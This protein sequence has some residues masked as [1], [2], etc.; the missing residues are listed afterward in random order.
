MMLDH[1]TTRDT[2][3]KNLLQNLSLCEWSKMILR[4]GRPSGTELLSGR[5]GLAFFIASNFLM[6]C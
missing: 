2:Q 4:T 5:G 3:K 6:N 1:Y